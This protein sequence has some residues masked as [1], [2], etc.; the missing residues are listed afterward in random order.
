M[1]QIKDI[2]RGFTLI[3][4]L[5]AILLVGL[6]AYLVFA[7][8][9]TIEKPKE[10]VNISNLPRVLQK[11]LSGNGELICINKCKTCYYVSGSQQSNQFSLPMKLEVINEFI[12]D[13]NSN[14]VKLDLGRY[15][16]KKICMRLRHYKNGSISQVILDLGSSVIFI[17]SYFGKGKEFGSVNE[18]A[19]WWVR[20]SQDMLRSKGD[21]Y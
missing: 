21:W 8:P 13:K 7:T 9:G 11:N 1:Q 6:F 19:K 10:V 3:E 5:L 16:D 2:R 12:L 20:D 17:P 4:L 14:P 15:K 18:A